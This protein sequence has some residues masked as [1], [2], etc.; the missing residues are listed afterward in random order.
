[1]SGQEGFLSTVN[2]HHPYDTLNR[3]ESLWLVAEPSSPVQSI[4]E[5]LAAAID[6]VVYVACLKNDVFRVTS[7]AEVSG[8]A[9][10]NI[11]LSEIFKFT[12]TGTTAQG[13]PAGTLVPTGTR[14]LFNS[15]LE[16]AGFLFGPEIYGSSLGDVLPRKH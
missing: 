9:G 4:R 11:V 5:Q 3:L 7:V 12:Q 13:S 10:G 16:T 8:I 14:P 6:L 15:R 1:C 2:A